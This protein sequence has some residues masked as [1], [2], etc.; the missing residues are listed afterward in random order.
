MTEQQWM[1]LI[2]ALFLVAFLYSSVGHG[3]A[4]GYLALMALFGFQQEIIKPTALVI[5]V[6]IS[7]IAF[8]QFYRA[9]YFKWKLFV[10]FAITSIPAAF[11]GGLLVVDPFIYKK[12]LGLILLFPVLRLFGFFGQDADQLRN[13]NKMASLLIGAGIGFISGLIG[14]GGGILLSPVIL[15]LHWG[16]MKETAAVSAL[17]IFVNSLA[18]LSGQ[19]ISGIKLDSS[20]VA[21]LCIAIAGGLTGSYYGVNKFNSIFLRRILAFV[22]LVASVKLMSL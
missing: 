13:V 20:I 8:I 3:G 17:F 16:R 10:P 11:L 5:N 19:F 22:L 6:V 12:I 21:L 9:G 2:P 15:L 7:F 14:I 1:I 18:G 4:S